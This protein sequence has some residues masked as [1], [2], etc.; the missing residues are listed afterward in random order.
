MQ[1]KSDVGGLLCDTFQENSPKL[2]CKIEIVPR[3]IVGKFFCKNDGEKVVVST[4]WSL[5]VSNDLAN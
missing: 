2:I 1:K 3:I 4:N 5:Q